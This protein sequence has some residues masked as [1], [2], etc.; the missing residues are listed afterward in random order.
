MRRRQRRVVV[1]FSDNG[2][3]T[4]PR[5]L[6]V[7]AEAVFIARKHDAG[8]RFPEVRGKTKNCRAQPDFRQQNRRSR[9]HKTRVWSADLGFTPHFRN[10]PSEVCGKFWNPRAH[11]PFCVKKPRVDAL[12]PLG[13]VDLFRICRILP[14]S[15]PLILFSVLAHSKDVLKTALKILDICLGSVQYACLA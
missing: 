15:M 9:K 12:V 10:R 5:L 13:M 11:R 8:S 3:L 6:D 4:F 14:D 1:W 2:P 7:V